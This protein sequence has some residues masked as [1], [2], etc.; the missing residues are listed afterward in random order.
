LQ[1]LFLQTTNDLKIRKPKKLRQLAD[2]DLQGPP[3]LLNW[4]GSWS[5]API[6]Y[7]NPDSQISL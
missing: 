2:C 1:H 5:T 6:F 7:S 3:N 4:C